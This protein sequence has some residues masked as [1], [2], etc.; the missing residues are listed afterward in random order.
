MLKDVKETAGWERSRGEFSV[1]EVPAVIVSIETFVSLQKDAETILGSDGAS[2]LLYEAGKKSGLRWINRFSRKWGLKDKSSLKQSRIYMLNWG[3]ASSA[4][5]KLA[6]M[7]LL[8][9]L[10]IHLLR[11]ATGIQKFLSAIS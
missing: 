11:E 1:I 8:S 2:V 10:R 7:S 4:W 9:W 6:I 5:K 3:G